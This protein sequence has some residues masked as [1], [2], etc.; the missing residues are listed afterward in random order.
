MSGPNWKLEDDLKTVTVTFP[1]NPPVAI[2]ISVSELE[3][4]LEN[5]GEFRALMQP[6]IPRSWPMGQKFEAVSD[7]MWVT[8]PEMMQ[9]N[10]VVH[11]RDPRYGWLHYMIPREE[12]KKLA[13]YL[14][15]QA[16]TLPPVAGS[17]KV[18]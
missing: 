6:E 2:Q 14:Q 9:G 13:A 1:S 4:M 17:G 18:N 11:I 12:A 16:E 7:P 8:E 3:L 10:S 15:K 5:L